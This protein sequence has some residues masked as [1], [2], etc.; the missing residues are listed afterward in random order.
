MSKA[1]TRARRSRGFTL[2]EVMV[3][4][5]VLLVGI[6]GLMRLQMVGVQA[7]QASRAHTQALQVARELALG[8]ERLDWS[9]SRVATIGAAGATPPSV[10]GRILDSGATT[11]F[12]TWS[13]SAP[14]PGVRLDSQITERDDDGT[15]NFKRRWTIWDYTDASGRPAAGKLIAVSV[16]FHER[17]NNI[18]YEVVY[19]AFQ[20]NRGA[21]IAN[22]GAYQ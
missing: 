16:V 2:I 8:L 11:G 15:P 21:A 14:V 3:A 18:P 9:D 4:L 12:H 1:I 17:S 10:F 7:N 13:D 6:L 22:A 20:G 19:Y 5:I